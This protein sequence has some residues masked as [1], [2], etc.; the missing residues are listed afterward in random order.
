MVKPA[1]QDSAACFNFWLCALLTGLREA[2]PPS[3]PQALTHLLVLFAGVGG[4]AEVTR[5]VLS[6]PGML[7]SYPGDKGGAQMTVVLSSGPHWCLKTEDQDRCSE[8][9]GEEKVCFGGQSSPSERRARETN[10][11]WYSLSTYCVHAHAKPLT[12][13]SPN[14]DCDPL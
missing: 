12:S 8:A 14:S 2:A 3:E 11:S 7:S 1:S 10:S 6:T 4:S 5:A 9:R 13:R